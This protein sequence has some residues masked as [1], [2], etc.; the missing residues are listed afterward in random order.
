MCAAECRCGA[1]ETVA[2]TIQADR[3]DATPRGGERLV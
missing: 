1:I 3:R 2:K